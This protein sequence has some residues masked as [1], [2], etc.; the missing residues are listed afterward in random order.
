MKD[1][2]DI[3]QLMKPKVPSSAFMILFLAVLMSIIFSC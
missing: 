1:A 3:E 2:K